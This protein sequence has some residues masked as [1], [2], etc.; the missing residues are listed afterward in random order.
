MSSWCKLCANE[1]SPRERKK[2]E[3]SSR[4]WVRAASKERERERERERTR[5]ARNT[6][7]MEDDRRRPTRKTNGKEGERRDVSIVAALTWCLLW[8][9]SLICSLAEEGESTQPAEDHHRLSPLLPSCL[10]PFVRPS[11]SFVG[12][13]IKDDAQA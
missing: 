4:S 8:F 13:D 5:K 12:A 2:E 1:H 10:L 3:R 6:H 9:A 7:G 11:A